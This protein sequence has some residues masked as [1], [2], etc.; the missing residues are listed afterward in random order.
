MKYPPPLSPSSIASLSPCSSWDQIDMVNS[1]F[2]IDFDPQ[3]NL[4]FW[5]F[6]P[7]CIGASMNHYATRDERLDTNGA[8]VSWNLS[9][10]PK[11]GWPPPISPPICVTQ[12]HRTLSGRVSSDM[13]LPG[14]LNDIL[15]DSLLAT[16]YTTSSGEVMAAVT[17]LQAHGDS[18][19]FDVKTMVLANLSTLSCGQ[20][21]TEGYVC[22]AIAASRMK[23]SLIAIGT[24]YGIL[25]NKIIE[26]NV[27]C[28]VSNV[29][30]DASKHDDNPPL[31]FSPERED[32]PTQLQVLHEDD[33]VIDLTHV[34]QLK[35]IISELE[36]LNCELE[37]QF[38][39]SNSESSSIESEK[40]QKELKV[41]V[42]AFIA[43]QRK[44]CDFTK[45]ELDSAIREVDFLENELV[46]K[47]KSHNAL[48]IKSAQ[49]E[50]ELKNV[51]DILEQEKS[52]NE[53]TILQ[54]VAAN[55]KIT[56]LEKEIADKSASNEKMHNENDKLRCQLEDLESSKVGKEKTDE[57]TVAHPVLNAGRKD[58]PHNET[59]DTL[60]KKLSVAKE[61]EEYLR[62]YIHLLEEDRELRDQ[63]I[64]EA[65]QKVKGYQALTKD[66]RDDIKEQKMSIDSLVNLLERQKSD[67][68]NDLATQND[69][70]SSLTKQLADLQL[71]LQTKIDEVYKSKLKYEAAQDKILKLETENE[72]WKEEASLT[73][74]VFIAM[75][76]ELQN[77][78]ND[79]ADYQHE[80]K[81]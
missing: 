50:R 25:V 15:S 21:S 20:G 19:Q 33:R 22:Y 78:L 17:N 11:S 72:K 27:C 76:V 40:E 29:Q 3:R 59:L 9:D 18:V 68:V 63:E 58:M 31:L 66:L 45:T 54:L 43:D 10:L 8:L 67:H 71:E 2:E 30:E 49:L 28:Q 36:R 53:D 48:E 24:Q 60:R 6:S 4:M 57:T 64:E 12:L 34:C 61:T 32:Y 23:P 1:Q 51:K 80:N 7:D 74:K 56:I 38:K 47:N 75:K 14:I 13:V 39:N 73:N 5:A 65:R 41:R 46:M 52:R 55:N 79:L 62:N 26:S 81:S 35:M 16:I 69:N 42:S 44:F 70:I 77:A 37:S